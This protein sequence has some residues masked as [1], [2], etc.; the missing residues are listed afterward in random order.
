MRNYFHSMAV[1]AGWF[2]LGVFLLAGAEDAENVIDRISKI[3]SLSPEDASKNRP[4]LLEALVLRADPQQR[5]F[6][7]FDQSQGIYVRRNCAR[8]NF[9]QMNQPGAGDWVRIRGVT[10]PG[11]FTPAIVATEVEVLGTRPLPEPRP[12]ELTDLYDLASDCNWVTVSGQLTSLAV[13][14]R[15]EM[16]AFEL[17]LE[18][19]GAIPIGLRFPYVEEDEAALSKMMFHHVRVHALL[20]TVFNGRRQMTG[21]TLLANSVRNIELLAEDD[22]GTEAPLFPVHL[23]M[24]SEV[25]ISH[26]VR[27]RGVVTYAGLREIF[28]RGERSSLKVAVRDGRGLRVGQR[29]ELNGLIWPQLVSPA[30]RARS[31]TVL[32]ESSPAPAPQEFRIEDLLGTGRSD[33]LLDSRMNYELVKTRARLV[34]VGKSFGSMSDVPNESGQQ[35]LL[36]RSGEHLFEARLPPGMQ[37]SEKL[38][39][40]AVLEL[41]GICNLIKNDRTSSRLYFKG[42][43]LQIRSEADVAIVTQVPWWTLRRMLWITGAAIGIAG[44][45]LVWVAALRKTVERQTGLIGEKIEREI[46]LNERQRI[47]RELHDSLAQG[48]TALSFQLQNI[49]R[50]FKKDPANG[51]QAVELA[52]NML[53]ICQE[54]SRASISDLRGGILEEMD[55]PAA[56]RQTLELLLKGTD[57]ELALELRGEPVRLILFAE[58]HILRMITE[59]AGNALRHANPALLTVEVCYEPGSFACTVM[60][61][62]KG[63]VVDAL[64]AAGRFGVRGLYE[65]ANRLRGT[66]RLDS[67]PGRG[68]TLSFVMPTAEYLKENSHG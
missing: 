20:G 33:D 55:L 44:L 58:H 1:F 32:E 25:S 14:R 65:R 17:T 41:T 39:P 22:S 47:A 63:F 35:S 56:I 11:E 8:E 5:N 57:V 16:R 13:S 37:I 27:T 31:V 48:L 64:P 6:F 7:V 54:E 46:I 66:L 21:R 29:V 3:R 36:C 50:K 24:T 38:R 34:D 62:G 51:P 30:F 18:L 40:G 23:L 26:A 45:F 28:I 67:E 42:L 15:D 49:K 12:F 53:R 9:R 68:T 4:V 60:D 10:S 61:D 43:W 19:Y 59:A 52:E 2:F